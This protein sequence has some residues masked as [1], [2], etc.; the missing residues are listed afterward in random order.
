MAESVGRGVVG[1][2]RAFERLGSDIV[3][4]LGDRT[5]AFAAATAAVLSGRLLAHIHGGDRAEGG[6]DDYMRHAITK[7]AHCTSPRPKAPRSA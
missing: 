6:Y 1:F 3:V 2:T 5:E 4:V 7:M